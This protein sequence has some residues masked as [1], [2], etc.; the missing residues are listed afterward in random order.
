LP[1]EARERW[2]RPNPLPLTVRSGEEARKYLAL[3]FGVEY[4][5]MDVAERTGLPQIRPEADIHA[6]VRGPAA[7]ATALALADMVVEA[8]RAARTDPAV[9]RRV[10]DFGCSSGRLARTLQR[11]YPQ[12]DWHGCDPNAD[13]IAWANSVEPDV[14]FAVSPQDPPLEYPNANFDIVVAISVWSHFSE[15]A[16]TDW[17]EEMHRCIAPGGHLVLTVQ[18]YGSI[19][20][21]ARAR[22]WAPED[23]AEAVRDLYA[24]GYHFR[25][26]FGEDGDWGVIHPGWGMAFVTTEWILRAACP[27][28]EFVDYRVAR[29]ELNQDLV[30]LRRV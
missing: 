7:L 20:H 24:G 26:V 29:L 10:L 5:L 4:G 18:G 17:L 2:Q 27:A 9:A 13:A 15:V 21:A 23:L 22:L 11:A 1:A 16:A 3:A 28:W 8:L 19:A 6:M 12:A 14:S 30:V 25:E